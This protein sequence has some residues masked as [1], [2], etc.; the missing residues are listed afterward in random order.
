MH[1]ADTRTVIA[2]DGTRLAAYVSGPADAGTTLVLAHG[3]T[4]TSVAWRPVIAQLHR[5]A[6][7]LRVVAYDQRH[8]GDSG[9]GDSTL[10]IDLLGADLGAV[11]DQLAPDGRLLLGG[12][13]MGGMTVLALAAAH[14]ELIDDRVDGV[15]L[16]GT[17][18]G[19]LAGDRGGLLAL[20][21][22]PVGAA[23]ATCSSLVDG[24]R[25]F[26]APVLPAYRRA[27]GPLLFGPIAAP[28]VVRVGTELI[29]GCR[30]RTVV[31][32]VPALRGHDKRNALGPLAAVPVHV[33]V[34]RYDRLTPPRHARYLAEH[35]DGAQLTVLPHCGHM[36]T[37]ECP[38]LLAR[39]IAALVQ[40]R[41]GDRDASIPA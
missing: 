27:L 39:T 11:V 37:L 3:W 20:F 15:L 41:E 1:A 19:D 6:P 38:Q 2:P 30:I 26:A 8:H 12:H 5:I 13:S 4:L 36:L 24:A 22:G 9:R 23:L 35:I 14:P 21:G 10:S 7:H 16:V 29:F 31:E 34:G 40:R 25:R 18:A 28:E 32:F 33:F 17:S